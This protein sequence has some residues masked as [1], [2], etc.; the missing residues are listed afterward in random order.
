VIGAAE[1]KYVAQ[2]CFRTNKCSFQLESS[3]CSEC[4]DNMGTPSPS[5]LL[6]M[7]LHIDLV[8]DKK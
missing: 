3:V 8:R 7:Y 2:L 4:K 6:C 1:A 5:L